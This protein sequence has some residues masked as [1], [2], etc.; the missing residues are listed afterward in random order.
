MS[1][2]SFI[3]RPQWIVDLINE[4]AGPGA[5]ST[6][7][8]ITGTLSSQ[9]DLQTALNNKV[10][11]S[12]LS[13]FG[14]TLIDDADASA[15]RTTLGLGTA[16]TLSSGDVDERARDAV[17]TALVAGAGITITPNDGADTITI[18][19][20]VGGSLWTVIATNTI[21]APVAQVDF[22]S[23]SGYNEILFIARGLT[24][25]SSGARK[26]YVSVDG[27]STFY[28]TS[29]D[30]VV[31][32]ST[33]IESNTDSFAVDGGAAST[34]ARTIISHIINYS[35]NGVEKI[36]APNSQNVHRIFVASTAPINALRFVNSAGN[37]TGGTITILGR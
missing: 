25:S 34:A 9:A 1:I 35:L 37:L 12:Q 28:T 6:W 21:S 2:G 36:A 11:D 10:D 5:G 22:T 32:S 29:G 14:A 23:I 13:A 18:S 7:G 30:Y 15:A 16:A 3:P 19:G 26:V 8:S 20:S 33:G 27:G 24:A 4:L 31:P 17:G